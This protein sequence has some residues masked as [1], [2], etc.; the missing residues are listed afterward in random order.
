MPFSRLP[1]RL[2]GF[3]LGDHAAE[4]SLPAGLRRFRLS[5]TI[6]RNRRL[7]GAVRKELR[8]RFVFSGLML[9]PLQ[10]GIMAQQMRVRPKTKSRKMNA[11]YCLERHFRLLGFPVWLLKKMQVPRPWEITGWKRAR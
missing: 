8:E 1:R 11:E 5:P 3:V 7:A 4:Q 9:Q 2:K 6:E 10:A